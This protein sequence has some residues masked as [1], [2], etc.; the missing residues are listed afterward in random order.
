MS[1]QSSD[2]GPSDRPVT[3][4]ARGIC[5]YYQTDRGC[6]AGDRCKFL[7]GESERLTPYDKQ[8]TC[9]FYAAG[10]CKRGEKCW[11]RHVNP[12]APSQ[13]E[14]G[15]EDEHVCSICYD[16]PGTFGLLAGCSHIFCLSCIKN[17]R[18]SEGKSED[19]V[20][21][22]TI[23]TCPMCRT[24]SRFVTPSAFF[25]PEGDPKKVEVIEK[26][27][28]SMARVKCKYFERS[29][30]SRRF[31]PFGRDC[32]YKHVNSDGT[33]YIFDHGVGSHTERDRSRRFRNDDTWSHVE[34][35]LSAMFGSP[36]EMEIAFLERIAAE[37]GVD[38]NA[39]P[40]MYPLSE[41]ETPDGTPARSA[42]PAEATDTE[43]PSNDALRATEDVPLTEASVIES[44]DPD[45]DD[46]VSTADD[47]MLQGPSRTSVLNPA[48]PAF[49]PSFSRPGSHLMPPTI[50]EL[51]DLRPLPPTS[52]ELGTG[53]SRRWRGS[54]STEMDA[55]VREIE[56]TTS[57][58]ADQ[59]NALAD[60]S[61]LILSPASDS[62]TRPSDVQPFPAEAALVQDADP[63]FMTDGRG[64]VVWSSTTVSRGCEGRRGRAASSSATVH[65][66]IKSSPDALTPEPEESCSAISGDDSPVQRAS[67][68]SQRLVRQRSLPIVGASATA[69]DAPSPAEFVTDGRGR[70]VFAS[71]SRDL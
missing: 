57:H 46:V 55:L 64:R 11:F 21:A 3:S 35:M 25:Y 10:Y 49:V 22:G 43:G 29:K 38:R 9:T 17:W 50:Y 70:V 69:P 41:D 68:L 34:F 45:E 52:N 65:P 47:E 6:Y 48:T 7:H 44:T 60:V 59:P 1:S 5:K 30:P 2:A 20:Q 12:S 8:K 51:D 26:Y 14:E 13:R 4:K 23:K 42:S 53:P 36:R 40:P 31:C 19:I 24:S 71:S 63:P 66:H 37:F 39:L 27:K 16:V 58:G 56:G 67:G 28:A 61:S 32:F 15:S 54:D 62:P 33:P 18:G